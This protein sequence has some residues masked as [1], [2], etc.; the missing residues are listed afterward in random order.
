MAV[1]DSN[2]QVDLTGSASKLNLPATLAGFRDIHAGET[3]LVCGCGT[4]LNELKNPEKFITIGVS[5]VGRNFDPG[6]LVVLNH[7]HQFKDDRFRYVEQ[8]RARAIFTQLDLG[9]R[10]SHIVRFKRDRFHEDKR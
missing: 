4:S 7:H 5:D 9:L 2:L 8:S 3:L 6:Y 10:H 1:R